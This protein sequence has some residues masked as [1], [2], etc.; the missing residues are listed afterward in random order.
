V[1][2]AV[3][4]IDVRDDRPNTRTFYEEGGFEIPN[5][6]DTRNVSVSSY[7]VAGTPTTFLVD[8]GGRIVWR[9]YGYLPGEEVRLRQ[10]VEDLLGR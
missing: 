10:K 4:A 3:I 5:V 7:R 8:S 6:F 1:G 2:F 9:R